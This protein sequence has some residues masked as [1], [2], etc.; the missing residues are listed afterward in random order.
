MNQSR[1]RR[2]SAQGDGPPG[3][4]AMSLSPPADRARSSLSVR[5]SLYMGARANR[6]PSPPALL[7]I[8]LQRLQGAG[9]PQHHDRRIFL[10]FGRG[11]HLILGQFERDGVALVGNA[12]KPQRVPVDHALPA[13]DTEKAAE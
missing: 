8:E 4:N 3:G 2:L 12:A 7:V 9:S 5:P 13:A 11:F 6:M 10:V 1:P